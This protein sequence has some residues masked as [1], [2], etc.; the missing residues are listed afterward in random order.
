MVRPRATTL[1]YRFGATLIQPPTDNLYKFMAIVGLLLWVGGALY[2]WSKAYEI[3]KELI[4]L[5]AQIVQ[6]KEVPAK[7]DT[8][9][10]E[11]NL[12][13]VRLNFKAAIAYFVIG[14]LSF[15]SGGYL[16]F[17]GFRFWYFRV[18][19][20]MDEQVL[21]SVGSSRAADRDAK[22]EAAPSAD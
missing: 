13:L 6:A 11:K 18:Q 5:E 14:V 7:A 1:G 15:F 21:K 8:A 17:Y 4:T 22:R 16:M 3:E 9:L 19:K 12:K 10:L 20:P 2:P